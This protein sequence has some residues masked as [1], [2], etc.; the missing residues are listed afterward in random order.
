MNSARKATVAQFIVRDMAK[1][2]AAVEALKFQLTEI[3]GDAESDAELLRD[4]IEGETQLIETIDAMLRQIGADEAHIDGIAIE[5][6]RIAARKS[7]LD[8]RAETMRAMLASALEILGE[9]K[10]DRPLGVITLKPTAPKLVVT[11]EAAIPSQF[12]TTPAPTLARKDLADALKANSET[13]QGK[14]GEIAEAVAS[15][16]ID[17]GQGELNT[18]KLLAAFPG[19]PGAE[20]DGGGVTV[21]IRFS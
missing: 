20:L 16:A 1:E 19:I 12:W 6:K 2:L 5:Q 14:L 4:A 3:F 17:A 9:R 10:F 21:Q 13:L 18:E 7:R 11:D 8:K 15:G